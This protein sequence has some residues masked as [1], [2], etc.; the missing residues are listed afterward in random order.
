MKHKT[1]DL[2][3]NCKTKIYAQPGDFRFPIYRR[4]YCVKNIKKNFLSK[5]MAYTV[6]IKM[7]KLRWFLLNQKRYIFCEKKGK[8]KKILKFLWPSS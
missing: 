6:I 2:M 5:F 3:D 7:I 4:L 8:E 1:Q